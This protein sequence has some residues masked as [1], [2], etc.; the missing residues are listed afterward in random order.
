M[1]SAGGARP[2][3]PRAGVLARVT[4]QGSGISSEHL[5]TVFE[6]FFTTRKGGTGLG[7]YVCHEI[8]KRH[9]GALTVTSEVGRGTTFSVELPL[10][11]NG[12]TP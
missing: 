10:E 8:V 1:P 7:L 4:D 6:P 5:K 9:D 11:V 3:A 12:G 2:R